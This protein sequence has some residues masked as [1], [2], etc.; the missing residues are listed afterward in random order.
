M[1]APTTEQLSALAAT[2]IIVHPLVLLSVADHH[3]RA[4]SRNTNKRVIGVLLGQDNGKTI[5][6]ANSFGIPFEEDEK[7]SKTWFLDHNYIEG[8]YE[9]FKKVNAKERLI[10]WYHTGPK[11]RASDQEINDLFKRFIARPIMVIVDVRPETVG[12]PTDAYFAV[13]EI[14]DDGT[15]TRKTFLHCPSA[16]E[17][18]EAEEI[19]VEHLLRDIKDST[20]TTLATRVSEQLSSLRG[21][22]SRLSDVQK[23]LADVAAGTM[24]V[25]HQIVYH[26]QDALNLLPDLADAD[27]TQSFATSTNDELLVVYLSS[28][29]RAVIALHALVDNKATIGRAELEEDEKERKPGGKGEKNDTKKSEDKDSS[30]GSKVDVDA[31]DKGL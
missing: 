23:Y 4:V 10:G 24:P 21:L 8:M 30:K 12:I 28:L 11:L 6:V 18:E 20:T 13:E 9:M 27:T 25:N 1:V 15:E 2:T 5:N 29:L 22:Q 31:K 7:D 14:K 19:G 17:A 16:I 3:A 26:L